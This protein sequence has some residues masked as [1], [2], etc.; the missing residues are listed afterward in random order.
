[1]YQRSLS[2]AALLAGL[3]GA[4][5]AQPAPAA[6]AP[7]PAPGVQ[8]TDAQ[9]EALVDTYLNDPASLPALSDE[10]LHRLHDLAEARRRAAAPR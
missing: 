1:M 9:L 4:A 6:P 7:A 2:I 5:A 3:A 10:V 8:F